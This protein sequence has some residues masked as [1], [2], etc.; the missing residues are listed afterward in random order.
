[1]IY[2]AGINGLVFASLVYSY[3]TIDCTDPTPTATTGSYSMQNE[4][5]WICEEVVESQKTMECSHC[6]IP[7]KDTSRKH[8]KMS[9]GE[10]TWQCEE[11][12][13]Q[14]HQ[15][16]PTLS[17]INTRSE[18]IA[19]STEKES[20]VQSSTKKSFVQSST[21]SIPDDNQVGSGPSV[22][23]FKQVSLIPTLVV[24]ALMAMI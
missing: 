20:T 18:W 15:Q 7:A 23:G 5:E 2:K 17:W 9:D 6:D 8:Y 10:E 19:N 13:D 1:M 11:D 22:D 16:T 4:Y 3:K 12:D 21:F 14:M 24:I